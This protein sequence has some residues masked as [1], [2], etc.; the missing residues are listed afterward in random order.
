LARHIHLK[1]IA[2]ADIAL[3]AAHGV[4]KSLRRVFLH[5]SHLRRARVEGRRLG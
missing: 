2:F 5:A 3:N 4:G 1:H